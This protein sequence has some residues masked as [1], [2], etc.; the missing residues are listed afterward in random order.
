MTINEACPKEAMAK[1]GGLEILIQ[2]VQKIEEKIDEIAEH[3]PKYKD[4]IR[5]E[6]YYFLGKSLL[7]R[8]VNSLAGVQKE[9]EEKYEKVEIGARIDRRRVT[10][11]A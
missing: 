10:R 9:C 3:G 11:T 7:S 4:L 8:R 6:N 5:M 2:T 1:D